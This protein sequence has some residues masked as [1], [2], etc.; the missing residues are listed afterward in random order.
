MQ[1]RRP[2]DWRKFHTGKLV[3]HMFAYQGSAIR[4]LR[5]AQ[6]PRCRGLFA[7]AIPPNPTD[8]GLKTRRA[9]FKY[10]PHR[11]ESAGQSWPE[12]NETLTCGYVPEGK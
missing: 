2:P 3:E 6:I 9:E 4:P 10:T 5:S 7:E 12:P 1:D 8:A 11:A